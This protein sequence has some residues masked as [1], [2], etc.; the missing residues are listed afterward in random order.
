MMQSVVIV[1]VNIWYYQFT[2]VHCAASVCSCD[3][4]A[5]LEQH[6]RDSRLSLQREFRNAKPVFGV[7][8]NSVAIWSGSKVRKKVSA[9]ILKK[10]AHFA[11]I[12]S[13]TNAHYA[14]AQ[15][16]SNT[17]ERDAFTLSN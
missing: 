9:H 13:D 11:Q 16:V 1:M 2:T 15:Y 3:M 12:N 14:I 7:V 10:L 17:L 4:H 8:N 5:W 6:I